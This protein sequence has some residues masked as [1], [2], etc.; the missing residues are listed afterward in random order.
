MKENQ[1][2][3]RIYDQQTAI[4]GPFDTV[5]HDSKGQKHGSHIVLLSFKSIVTRITFHKITI[6]NTH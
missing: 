6:S 5:T 3:C 2:T 1:E 4:Y